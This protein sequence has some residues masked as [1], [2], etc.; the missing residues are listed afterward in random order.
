MTIE[1]QPFEDVFPIEHRDFPMSNIVI[2][3]CHVSFQGC[4]QFHF[5]FIPFWLEKT[6]GAAPQHRFARELGGTL[7]DLHLILLDV[8]VVTYI[9]EYSLFSEIFRGETLVS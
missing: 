1:H 6:P 5:S 4:I 3:Q 8:R 9:V 2:F 7:G